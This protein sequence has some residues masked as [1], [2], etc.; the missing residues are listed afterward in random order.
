MPKRIIEVV[1]YNPEWVTVFEKEKRLIMKAMRPG[2]IKIHH[3]GST[4]VPNLDAKPI[5]DVLVET[6]SMKSLEALV[7]ALKQLGY[8]SK[9]EFGIVGR[10][11]FQKGGNNRTHHLHAFQTGD[12]NVSRHLAFR[13]YLVA[14]P[15]I[16]AEYGALKQSVV[17]LCN[18]D[19]DQYGL[20]KNDFVKEHEAK[21]LVFWNQQSSVESVTPS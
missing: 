21:A 13:D 9:G 19:K 4:A 14:N 17:R 16:A 1:R 8:E 10:Q 18:N 2:I 3:I 12:S 7:P 6:D 5:I 20:G 15:D 11:Y